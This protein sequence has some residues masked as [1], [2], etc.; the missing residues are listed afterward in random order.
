MGLLGYLPRVVGPG[1][2][3]SRLGCL[4]CGGEDPVFALFALSRARSLIKNQKAQTQKKSMR[5]PQRYFRRCW[6]NHN[7]EALLEERL[8]EVRPEPV[9][10]LKPQISF[11][12]PQAVGRSQKAREA[13]HEA[14]VLAQDV[15]GI[16][17]WFRVCGL[18]FRV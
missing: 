4:G 13:L 6:D 10:Q 14:L 18:W 1:V 16:R 3:G 11:V 17:T 8:A 7:L 15:V 5:H 12:G 9:C 2:E